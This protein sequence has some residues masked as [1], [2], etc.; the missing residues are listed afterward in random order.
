MDIDTTARLYA[1][2][3]LTTQLISEFLRTVPEPEKQAAW[4]REH[5]HRLAETMP[6]ESGGF[7]E[8]ARLRVTIKDAVGRTLDAALLRAQTTPLRPPSWDTGPQAG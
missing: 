6:V 1:L 2:E 4:A 8:E 7:D 5:L 3:L